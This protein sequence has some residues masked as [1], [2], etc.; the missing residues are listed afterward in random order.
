[1]KNCVNTTEYRKK[2]VITSEIFQVP[3]NFFCEYNIEKTL[4]DFRKSF[5]VLKTC[6][7]LKTLPLY[8]TS[9]Y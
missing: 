9:F 7:W 1:M 8:H 4:K 6:I 2:T 3:L 5:G